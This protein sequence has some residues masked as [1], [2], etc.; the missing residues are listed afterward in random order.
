MVMEQSEMHSKIKEACNLIQATPR[1]VTDIPVSFDGMW[2]TC[3]HSSRIG[4]GCV[5]DILTGYVVDFE[6]A[7]E[8]YR[9][10]SNAKKDLY[11]SIIS[12]LARDEFLEFCIRCATQNANESLHGIM[13]NKNLKGKF[14]F[15]NRIRRPGYEEVYEFNFCVLKTV[16]KQNNSLGV[17]FGNSSNQHGT[18]L[19]KKRGFPKEQHQHAR[20]LIKLTMERQEHVKD[21]K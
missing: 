10:C 1:L 15:S 9:L 8:I 6:I 3:G 17:S 16:R 21:R 2:P 19:C 5:I 12:K 7:A 18:I 4:I 14:A 11:P 20:K 13:W